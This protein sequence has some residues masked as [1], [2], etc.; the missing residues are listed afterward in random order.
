L[1]VSQSEDGLVKLWHVT[2]DPEGNALM[3][4]SGWL[5]DVALSP[6]G[7]RLASVTTDSFVVNLWDLWVLP[8]RSCALLTN[9]TGT[10][11]SAAFS[12]DGRILATGSHDQTVRLWDV[13]NH[14]AVATLTNG[15]PVGSIAFSPDGQTL[16]VGGSSWYMLEGVRAGLQFW[17]VPSSRAT[18]TIAGDPSD[19]VEL[20]LSANGTLL[21]TG[22][23]EGAVSL[24]EAQ[25]R[26]L[27]HQFKSQF[28]SQVISLAFSPTESLLAASDMGGN[29]VLYNTTTMEVVLPPMKAHTFRVMSL[30]FSPDGRTLASAGEGGGLKL[31]HVATRQ[32]ALTLKGHVGTVTG[33]AFSR[34]GNFMASC[35]ADATVRIWP[36]A[37]FEGADAATKPKKENQ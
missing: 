12:P 14:Q 26:R 24:W 32:V 18:G 6:D 11:M 21:A 25:T 33:V 19:I 7:R 34:D 15:F 30:A 27:L 2:T 29:I 36:A 35:G 28:G 22:H 1:L 13:N 16:I 31:W 17:D 9:H 8:T 10:V 3:G 5:Q 20:A 37:P 4:S 23:K